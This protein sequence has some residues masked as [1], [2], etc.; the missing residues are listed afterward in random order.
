MRAKIIFALFFASLA[1]FQQASATGVGVVPDRLVFDGGE[2]AF[3]IV[4]PNTEELEF[5]ITSANISC[6][7][8]EGAIPAKESAEIRCNA[9]QN[10]AQ[11]TQILVE[12]AM[13]NGGSVNMMPA[14]AVKAEIV[15]K[16]RENTKAMPLMVDGEP[17]D[18]AEN[19]QKASEERTMT[20]EIALIVALA[21]AIMLVLAY[22]DMKKRKIIDRDGSSRQ[23]AQAG[24]SSASASASQSQQQQAPSHDGPAGNPQTSPPER[25]S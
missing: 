2:K 20:P 22:S 7:P 21:A 19:T 18:P 10:A 6:V 23:D 12:T 5:V 17:E 16:N 13:I 14:V 1:L 4:N 11:E 8:E 25:C 9:E 3:R 24:Q 15:G